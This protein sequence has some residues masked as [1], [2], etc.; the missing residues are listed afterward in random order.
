MVFANWKK[1]SEANVVWIQSS[2]FSGVNTR[3]LSISPPV[4]LRYPLLGGSSNLFCLMDNSVS[5]W[6]INKHEVVAD[7]SHIKSFDVFS[8]PCIS[9]YTTPASWPAELMWCT[10][11][12]ANERISQLIEQS[13]LTSM[14]NLCHKTGLYCKNNTGDERY[15]HIPSICE[16]WKK[17]MVDIYWE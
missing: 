5:E 14:T 17:Y 4:L 15:Y 9:L 6:D 1:I 12:I 11:Q 3:K 2:P 16:C 13:M 10:W 7:W 8:L